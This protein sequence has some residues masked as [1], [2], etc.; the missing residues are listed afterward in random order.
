MSTHFLRRPNYRNFTGEQSN[1]QIS[2]SQKLLNRFWWN[3]ANKLPLRILLTCDKFGSKSVRPF[4][5]YGA[6]N[7]QTD[8]YFELVTPHIARVEKGGY[9]KAVP[10]PTPTCMSVYT[11]LS[12]L[13]VEWD[14][15][16]TPRFPAFRYTTKSFI[17]VGYKNLTMRCLKLL[18]CYRR[19]RCKG[20]FMVQL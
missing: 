16:K 12:G 7:R 20:S 15:Y 2:V 5:S 3:I 8:I 18:W 19:W 14:I 9:C 6:M 17:Y 1:F 11:L 10:R 4:N 13:R